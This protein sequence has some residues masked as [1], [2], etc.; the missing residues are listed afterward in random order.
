MPQNRTEIGLREYP[1]SRPATSPW[2][3]LG[4]GIAAT[5]GWRASAP[6][7]G[8]TQGWNRL[9]RQPGDALIAGDE[10]GTRYRWLP[11][12]PRADMADPVVDVVGIKPGEVSTVESF[13][14]RRAQPGK[15][16]EAQIS[17]IDPAVTER[18]R[19]PVLWVMTAE[20]DRRDQ[21]SVRLSIR[22]PFT[23][24]TPK[25]HC[26]HAYYGPAAQRQ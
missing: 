26:R 10:F 23:A 13:S 9:G 15:V 25:A 22:F 19:L 18:V 2:T 8:G 5:H 7:G 21:Q 1:R 12:E 17:S 3:W 6:N 11:D 4:S 20:K 24:T 14:P 16:D